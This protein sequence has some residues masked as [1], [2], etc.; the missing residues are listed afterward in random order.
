[1]WRSGSVEINRVWKCKSHIARFPHCQTST[2]PY[3][4]FNTDI[5][6][7]CFH[8]AILAHC[9]TST[10]P[11]FHTAIVWQWK[12]GSVEVWQ[13]WKYERLGKH[14]GESSS[15]V[16]WV[17]KTKRSCLKIHLYSVF[18]LLIMWEWK[19]WWG[20]RL[21][22]L[23]FSHEEIKERLKLQK[24]SIPSVYFITRPEQCASMAMCKYGNVHVYL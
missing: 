10:L 13:V 20:I 5:L 23:L 17:P 16:N 9:H 11:Y 19:S 21:G 4:Y 18:V 12:Y 22:R 3:L 1:M 2:L 8:T 6:P 7:H 15:V 24:S 14:L